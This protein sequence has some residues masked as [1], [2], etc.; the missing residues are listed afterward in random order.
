MLDLPPPTQDP[1]LNLCDDCFLAW[2][3]DPHYQPRYQR[4]QS[5]ENL[6]PEM[7]TEKMW[8]WLSLVSNNGPNKNNALYSVEV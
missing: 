3:V 8:G 7:P 5:E 4:L 1:E 6:P 2:R